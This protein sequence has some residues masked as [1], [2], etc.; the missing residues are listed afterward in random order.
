MLL[1]SCR[2]NNTHISTVYVHIYIDTA[3]VALSCQTICTYPH[4][5]YMRLDLRGTRGGL[6]LCVNLTHFGILV[7]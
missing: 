3:S 5:M 7:L 1:I 2:Y 6:F 4:W